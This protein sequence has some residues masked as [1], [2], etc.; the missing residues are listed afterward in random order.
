MCQE[1]RITFPGGDC[2]TGIHGQSC[3]A[4]QVRTRAPQQR[5]EAENVGTDPEL[6][7]GCSGSHG[8]V[9][10]WGDIPEAA[11]RGVSIPA[12]DGNSEQHVGE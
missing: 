6:G 2:I 10:H 8:P 1:R 4:T 11:E 5:R 7:N 9:L 12:E 3:V